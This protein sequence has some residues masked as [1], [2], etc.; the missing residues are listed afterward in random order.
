[1]F[2]SRRGS[3]SGAIEVGAIEA[4]ARLLD[5]SL[6]DTFRDA[7]TESGRYLAMNFEASKRDCLYAFD[8]LLSCFNSLSLGY[9]S[10]SLNSNKTMSQATGTG[11]HSLSHFS[12]LLELIHFRRSG[13]LSDAEEEAE[14]KFLNTYAFR[15]PD[16]FHNFTNLQFLSELTFSK[17]QFKFTL[18]SSPPRSRAELE[19]KKEVRRYMTQQ[20]RGRGWHFKLAQ[21]PF[22]RSAK[23]KPPSFGT[24]LSIKASILLELGKL[25]EPGG[26]RIVDNR[27]GS[28]GKV[29]SG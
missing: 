23:G 15:K 29:K 18:V 27:N 19:T 13:S 2:R 7:Q 20:L 11:R 21:I 5:L 4:R 3:K 8:S 22:L 14:K 24:T 1:L 26:S 16:V 17:L 28:G 10:T 25:I 6:L 12:M 9:S